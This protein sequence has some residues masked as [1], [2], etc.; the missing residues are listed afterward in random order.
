M[1]DIIVLTGI[2]GSGKSTLG[3][4]FEKEGYLFFP[5]IGT[6]LREKWDCNVSQRQES[7]DQIVMEMELERDK[8]LEITAGFPVVESWHIGNIAF[9][10]ARGSSVVADMYIRKL[11]IQLERFYPYIIRLDIDKD[12]FFKRV[13]EKMISKEDAWAFYAIQKEYTNRLVE[14][15]VNHF[16]ATLL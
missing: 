5:E 14:F 13:N 2:H 6:G 11:F 1:K 3:R 8:E 15:L 7:F 4:K 12:L 16:Y 9:A 10:Q